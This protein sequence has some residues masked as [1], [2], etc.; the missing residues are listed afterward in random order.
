MRLEDNGEI[1]SRQ[2]QVFYT[3]VRHFYCTGAAYALLN[4]PLKDA[5]L[6]NSEFVNFGS[7]ESATITQVTFFLSKY[8]Q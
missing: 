2:V 4:L 8:L 1:S 6:Q 3:A 7:R 5:V